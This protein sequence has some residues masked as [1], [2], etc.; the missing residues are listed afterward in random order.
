MTSKS[1]FMLAGAFALLLAAPVFAQEDAGKAGDD[2][3]VAAGTLGSFTPAGKSARTL[4]G[5]MSE[6]DSRFAFTPSRQKKDKERVTVEVIRRVDR[7]RTQPGGTEPT[8]SRASADTRA[9]KVATGVDVGYAGFSLSGEYDREEGRVEG[10]ERESVA[11]GLGYEAKTWRADVKAGASQPADQNIYVPT[12]LGESV[13]V[14]L[15]GA[16]ELNQRLSLKGGVRYDRIRPEAFTRDFVNRD[17]DR[18]KETGTV[19]LGTSLSF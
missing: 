16:F 15:G 9:V 3:R 1:S 11:V 13:S 14:E 7:A 8:A 18:A 6:I 5:R 2:A 17:E 12:P 4:P 10:S 19:Y